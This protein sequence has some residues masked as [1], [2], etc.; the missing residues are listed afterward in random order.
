MSFRSLKARLAIAASVS[1]CLVFNALGETVDA[2]SLVRI[3]AMIRQSRV[4]EA[5]LELRNILARDPRNSTA[6]TLL[7]SVCAKQEKLE[8]AES[9]LVKAIEHRRQNA[10]AYDELGRLYERYG[11]LEESLNVYENLSL[12]IPGNVLASTGAARIHLERKE[13]VKALTAAAKVPGPKQTKELLRVML[14]AHLALGNA[15]GAQTVLGT[16]LSRRPLEQKFVSSVADVFLERGMP[17]DAAQFLRIALPRQ[18]LN[19]WGLTALAKL[20][21]R[22][23]ELQLAKVTIARALKMN[24]TVGDAWAEQARIAGLQGN[25]DEAATSLK[26]AVE[27]EPTNAQWVRSL[28]AVL[29]ER[30]RIDDAYPHAS[31][32]YRLRPDDLESFVALSMVY[33]RG[34]AWA[35]ALPVV[36]NGLKTFPEEPRLHLAKAIA[37]FELGE[38]AESKAECARVLEKDSSNAEAHFYLGLIAKQEGDAQTAIAEFEKAVNSAPKFVK[39]LEALGPLYIDRG[40]L[41]KARDVLEQAGKINPASDSTHYQLVKVYSRLGDEARANFHLQEYERLRKR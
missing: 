35:A 27:L 37:K 28:V 1:L 24:P 3:R 12:E 16:V 18:G 39:A 33:V 19:A 30:G 17:G 25:W 29:L 21:D 36:E 11:R 23:G 32:L 6:E 15:D 7:A 41:E 2:N 22:Q 40:E 38:R 14:S 10:E 13:Y 20:Q 8:E 34:R 26:R 4:H 5:E 31:R 9:L